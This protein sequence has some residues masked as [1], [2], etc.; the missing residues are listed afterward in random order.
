MGEDTPGAASALARFLGALGAWAQRRGGWVLLAILAITVPCLALVPHPHVEMDPVRIFPRGDAAIGDFRYFS[1]NFGISEVMVLVVRGERGALAPKLCALRARLEASGLFTQVQEQ[2]LPGRPPATALLAF[3]RESSMDIALAL[4][5]RAEARA[6]LREVGVEADLTGSP[7]FVAESR[8]SVFHDVTVTG[9]IA[10]VLVA[11]FLLAMLRDPLM[12]VVAMV[13][14]GVGLV[15]GHALATAAFGH[16]DFLVAGLPASL[17]GMGIDYA[18]YLRVTQLEHAAEASGARLWERVYALIG[19]PMVVGVLTAAGAFFALFC[20]DMQ[21][22]ARM[23]ILGGTT[24]ALIFALTLLAAPALMEARDRLGLRGAPH[25]PRWLGRLAGAAAR[26]RP[27][28]LAAFALLTAPLLVSALRLRVT[29]DPRAYEDPSLPSR[30]TQ[31]ELAERMGLVLD[32]IL[33]ATTDLAAE[34]RVLARLQGLLGP[35]RLFSRAECLSA[36][37]DGLGLP[38]AVLGLVSGP[39]DSLVSRLPQA[40]GLVGR[41]GRRLLLLYPQGSP[42]EG[43]R[44]G[45]LVALAAVLRSE[46]GADVARV[47]GAPLVYHRLSRLIGGNLVRTSVAAGAVVVVVLAALL[48]RPRD[49]AA[50]LL[51]LAGALAWMFGIVQW[52]GWQLTAAN[53]VVL[54]LVVGLGVDYGVYILFRLRTA[55]L[56]RAVSTTGRAVVMAGGTTAAGFLAL[57]LARNHAIAGMGLAAGVG[58]LA[59][60]AWSLVFLPALLGGSAGRRGPT[61]GPEPPA[62]PRG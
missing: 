29:T 33:V 9:S 36:Y 57:V 2:P 14:L 44:L 22:F 50:A 26:A 43:E 11:A 31:A 8:D 17:V 20:A 23:G 7:V 56:E 28:T 1:E 19:P 16:V 13:P 15:W 60:L 47:S 18:V 38:P 46:C 21:S 49:V 40:R 51:P 52:A 39:L 5:L 41:D 6:A 4:A 59:C 35:G 10:A 3:Q 42:Y 34:R 25:N 12:A 37:T 53:M 27:W 55:S 45:E 48:R 24:L 54:P 62:A 61:P 30:R 32:P 58:I